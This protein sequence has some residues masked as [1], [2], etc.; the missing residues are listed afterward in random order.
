MVM[1][2]SGDGAG[3]QG[4]RSRLRERFSSAPLA[5]ADYEILELLLTYCLPRID[6]KPLSRRLLQRFGSFRGVMDA[7]QED[8]REVPGAGAGL[9]LFWNLLREVRARYAASPLAEREKLAT[10]AAVAAMARSRIGLC[11]EEEC[12]AAMVD[13]QNRLLA[14]KCIRQGGVGAVAV[15]PRDI[16]TA[17]LD[18]RARAWAASLSCR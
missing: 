15:T 14:W 16:L 6:T 5:L 2:K 7:S 9:A 17:A 18:A 1:K 11:R 8:L 13:A 3:S 10:P 12:W 4:H